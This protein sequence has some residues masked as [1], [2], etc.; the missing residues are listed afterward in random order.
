MGNS[1]KDILKLSVRDR[2]KAVE[3]IWDSI[4]ED[5]VPVT[6]DEVTI[7]K[8]R[9]EEYL[10]NPDDSI[11]WEKARKSLMKKYGF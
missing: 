7:A 5:S 2:M 1:V 8:E 11:K 9:Y 4:D 3:K 6:K 10:K